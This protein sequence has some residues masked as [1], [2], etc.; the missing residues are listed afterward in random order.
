[1]LFPT[2]EIAL[3]SSTLELVTVDNIWRQR[4][5][6][7]LPLNVCVHTDISRSVYGLMSQGQ[8]AG[9]FMLCADT[10]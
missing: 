3:I 2:V 1:M 9:R 8:F 7:R 10:K 6:E 4:K 5:W